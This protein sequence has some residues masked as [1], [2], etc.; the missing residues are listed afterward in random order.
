MKKWLLVAVGLIV[1]AAV[2]WYFLRPPVLVEEAPVSVEDAETMGTRAVTLYFPTRDAEAVR[3][4]VR[5]IRAHVRRDEEIEAVV[6]QLLVGPDTQGLISAMPPGTRLWHA[7]FDDKQSLVY[8]DFSQE[9]VSGL[10]GGS[11][12]ELM[13]LTS[14]LRTLAVAF[15]DIHG[16]QILVD[17]LEIETL[18]GHID[19]TEP[20]NPGDWL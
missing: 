5:N 13:V 18:A 17:G 4:E 2:A 14:L 9:L 20:L 16:A 3:G 12:T 6:E 7:F 15:P 11:T 19:L 10:R 8:L 1:G